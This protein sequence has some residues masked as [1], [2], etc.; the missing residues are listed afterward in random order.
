VHAFEPNNELAALLAQSAKENGFE[1]LAIHAVALSSETGRS[2]LHMP[3]GETGHA[4]LEKADHATICL[5]VDT[6]DA[7]S[8]L[9]GL[10]LGPIKLLKIDTE[11][12]E[13]PIFKSARNFLS[14]NPPRFIIFEYNEPSVP[15]WNSPLVRLLQSLHYDDFYCVPRT[16]LRTHLRAMKPGNNDVG[17]AI[18]FLVMHRLTERS[19]IGHLLRKLAAP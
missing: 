5:D 1:N 12:H 8:Y 16:Y 18:N 7:G 4:S 3:V 9:A 19:D 6:A 14:A 10:Q 11:K 2:V 13:Y 17:R 15:F